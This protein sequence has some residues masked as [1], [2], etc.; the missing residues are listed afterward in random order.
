M[1]VAASRLAESQIVLGAD[2][3]PLERLAAQELQRYLWLLTGSFISLTAEVPPA[4]QPG[5]PVLTV[6]RR[7]ALA[8]AGRAGQALDLAAL[9]PQGILLRA[10]HPHGRGGPLVLLAGGSPVATQWAV[11][12]FLEHLGCGFYLGGDALPSPQPGLAVPQL[13]HA[14][15]PVFLTRGTLP[16]YNFLNSP[17]VWNL[18]DYCR[19]FD[20]LAKQR[21][22]FVGF[23]SYDYEPWAAYRDGSGHYRAGAPLATSGS[24]VH[25]WGAVP[26]PTSEYAFGTARLYARELFGAACAL[27]YPTP[28]AGIAQQQAVLAQA[29]A[30][31]RARGI[32][33]CVGFEVHGDP[34]A[35]ET[36]TALRERLAHLVR[37]YPLDFVWIW[38][39]EGRGRRGRPP[40]GLPLAEAPEAA[41]FAY[42]DEPGRIAEGVRISR[43]ATLAHRILAE[44]APQVRLIVSGWGGDQWLHFTDFYLGLDR[45]L[46]PDIIFAALDNIDP[47]FEPQVSAVYGR[48]SPQ[49]QRWPILWFESDG[50]GTR[51]DQWGPQPNVTAFAPLVADAQAKGCQGILGIHWR[52]RAVEEVAAFTFQRAWD[53]TL[54]PERFFTR[55]SRA[56]YGAAHAE[57]MA[58]L[59]LQLERLG[60]RWTGAMG[61][62]ECAPFTWF[63]TT[64]HLLPPEEAVPPY[65]A[66]R[67]PR[68]QHLAALAQLEQELARRVAE[69]ALSGRRHLERLRYLLETVR[70]VVR[71]DQAALQ[72]YDQGPVETALR[73]AEEFAAA[74]HLPEARQAA[75]QA[76]ALLR[77]AGFRQAV[78]TLAA[79]VTNQGELGVLATVNGKAVAAYR[80][81]LRR[82]ERLLGEQVEELL[83]AGDW[84]AELHV[85]VLVTRDVVGPDESLTLEVRAAGP[86][87]ITQVG[88]RTRPLD[89]PA[90]A[91]WTLQPLAH[92]RGAVY[93]GRVPVAAPGLAYGVEVMDAR[94][95]VAH[96]PLGWPELVYTTVVWAE[97]P[98]SGAAPVPLGSGG[99]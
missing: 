66:G 90:Q 94:G 59:H 1:T 28:D 57:A 86:A 97:A 54:T 8:A 65:R 27:D 88:V 50:G 3:A 84:P 85:W 26:T 24:H 33:T 12:A 58:R 6:G 35:P 46:P 37:Q 47:T 7:A 72:L 91:P 93:R 61:Q 9:G 77:E 96:A 83:A 76:L 95:T 32:Q 69:A 64:G 43:Y 30:Y 80:A 11:Y 67:Y 36:A 16:W 18:A 17:T 39:A 63:S 53:P 23:H 19:F 2:A 89:A 52:T 79:N 48:L 82:V 15:Q 34:D 45:T 92:V 81:L 38:Q 14:A 29:L 98:V 70:W 41:A 78:Q 44:C 60:P 55:L 74:G 68:A 31:A 22:N 25:L 40:T 20:Q 5:G 99:A 62:V 4:D 75:R 87:P 71:Y 73:R 10:L 49:R 42:L 21:A 51:R 13:D 56:C